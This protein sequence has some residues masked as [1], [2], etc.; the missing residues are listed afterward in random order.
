MSDAR[1]QIVIATH[2]THKTGE[3]RVLLGPD[4]L[5]EDLTAYPDLPVPEEDGATFEENAAIKARS[6]AE[7][8]GDGVLVVAD[9]SGLEVDAL[10]GRPGIFSA[11]YA[12]P[13]A[14]DAGNRDRV[15]EEMKEVPQGS[16]TARFR[17]V[18]ILAEGGAG[19]VLAACDGTVEGRL[20]LETAG[21]GGFGYDPIFIPEGY[22]VTFGELPAEVKNSLSHRARALEALRR[23]LEA[24]H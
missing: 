5:V 23:R 16:R 10:D 21:T 8:L 20:A 3:F 2:N 14:G 24:V 17:C 6:A 15:L 1:K 22:D 19:T 11:R 9:D 7:R 13:G 12:G 4:W 18:L